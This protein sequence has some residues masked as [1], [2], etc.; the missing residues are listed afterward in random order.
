VRH[1]AIPIAILAGLSVI[2]PLRPAAAEIEPASPAGEFIPETVNVSVDGLPVAMGAA[3]TGT[4]GTAASAPAEA[5]IPF[6]MV[7]LEL[8]EG[9]TAELRTST[10]GRNWDSWTE[11][12]QMEADTGPDRGSAEQTAAAETT[13]FTEPL[14]VGEAAWLQ[15]RVDGGSPADVSANFI[16]TTGL[17]TDE[18][19]V[20]PAPAP[21]VE[22][23][24]SR[25][26]ITTRA[27][28]G[29]NESIRKGKASYASNVRYGVVHHTAGSNNY[30][31]ANGPAVVR[32]IYSYHVQSLGWSDVGY[33]L[34]VDKY[35]RIYE[36]RFGGLD[37][38]VVGAH[39]Q[40]FNTGSVGVAVLG[41]YTGVNVPAA[42]QNAVAAVLAWKF[43]LHGINPR[44]TVSVTSGGSNK[45][46]SGR[47]V[48][49]PTIIG[50][51]DVGQTACPG[52][53]YYPQMP[54]LRNAVASRITTTAPAPAPK[55]APTTTT[56]PKT[57]PP[58]GTFWDIPGN[59]HEANIK[60]LVK[61]GVTSGCGGGLFCPNQ[62]VTRSQA[63]ALLVRSL[64]SLPARSGQRFS[65]VPANHQFARPIATAVDAGLISGFNDG[66]F[67]PDAPLSREQMAT[68]LGRSAKLAK[69]QGQFFTDV[70]WTSPHLAYV[71]AVGKKKIANGCTSTRYCPAQN[72]SR[73][74]MASFIVRALFD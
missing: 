63:A 67:R 66:S 30:S 22:A 45:F 35:G 10:D 16:D 49:L 1:R 27:Q 31:A 24:A 23:N 29:A 65:D 32:G 3:S 55:P 72:V 61:E 14:W 58:A 37:R 9:A 28:W 40:G 48:S 7:G 70:P 57:P 43:K 20:A 42:G 41:D 44:G 5:P 18:G 59:V 13:R 52:N 34:L 15:V 6:N 50:H 60:R 68:I 62:S 19:H 71:N 21:G 17:S 46:P 74:Q 8:P 69:V 33:N 56:W 39:A 11:A 64:P 73:G 26:A 51:R 2:T 54:N 25:P 36:G 53:A 12:E 47:V 38:G 4:D